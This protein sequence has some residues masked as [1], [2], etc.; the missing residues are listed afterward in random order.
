MVGGRSGQLCRPPG[1]AEVFMKIGIDG[2]TW[3]NR[4]GYG[5]FTRMLV[6]TMIAEYPG[7]EFVLVVDQHTAAE[8]EFPRGARVEVVE[9]MEQ[10]TRAAAADG[11]RRPGDLW[12][13]G[14]A[15]SR[16]RFDAFLFP[17]SYSFFRFAARLA[18]SYSTT[19]SRNNTRS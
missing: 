5:R 16:M 2:C 3:A 15:V 4:R 14:R 6:S 11:A 19:R 12:K 9:L 1:A 7:H 18:Q 8:C 17:T 13:L 10:P